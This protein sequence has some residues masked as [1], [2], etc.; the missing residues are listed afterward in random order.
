M[1]CPA[2][3]VPYVPLPIREAV[4]AFLLSGHGPDPRTVGWLLVNPW[5]VLLTILAYL[6][7]IAATVAFTRRFGKFNL[8]GPLV[9]HNVVLF[10]LSL[11]MTVEIVRQAYLGGYKLWGNGL[12]TSSRSIARSPPRWRCGTVT[13]A[14]CLC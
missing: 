9:L 14:A 1:S 11:Y 4:D 5:H 6:V 3:L 8:R 12:D 10:F 13:S 7:V 2:F